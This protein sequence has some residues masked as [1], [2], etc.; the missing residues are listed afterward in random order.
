[1]DTS[2]TVAQFLKTIQQARIEWNALIEPIG[3][4]KMTQPG[5]ADAWSLKDIIAHIT[6]H[7]RQM[8]V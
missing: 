3:R 7:E 6:L 5:V 4:S 2:S 1:M 8:V